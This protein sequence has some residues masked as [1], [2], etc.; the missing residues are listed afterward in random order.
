MRAPRNFLKWH[1]DN[2]K[3]SWLKEVEAK[4]GKRFKLLDAEPL[5]DELQAFALECFRHVGFSRPPAFEGIARLPLSEIVLSYETGPGKEV[6]SL[7]E[8]CEIISGIDA[9]FCAHVA[10]QAKK[11][12][13]KNTEGDVPGLES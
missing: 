3:A 1:S 6:W 9:L 13:D 7:P 10:K 5:P 8:Y 2:P 11:K 12:A 4:T